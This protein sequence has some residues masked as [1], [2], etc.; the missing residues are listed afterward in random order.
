MHF[1]G[2][3]ASRV[4]FHSDCCCPFKNLRVATSNYRERNVSSRRQNRLRGTGSIERQRGPSPGRVAFALRLRARWAEAAEGLAGRSRRPARIFQ[5]SFHSVGS[6]PTLPSPS[7]DAPI[8][9]TRGPSDGSLRPA[10]P[11]CPRCCRP[12]RSSWRSMEWWTAST[13]SQ[14]SPPTSRSSGERGSAG[15]AA[16]APEAEGKWGAGAL[17]AG[18][19][20]GGVPASPTPP[21]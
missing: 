1:Q 21:G 19:C 9:R 10:R 3:F 5:A 2:Q 11:Q 17:D 12:A 15:R 13:A 20:H 16:G 4:P 18:C 6:T 14:A 7:P 8:S